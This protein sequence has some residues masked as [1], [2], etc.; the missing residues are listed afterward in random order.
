[1]V[2][3]RVILNEKKIQNKKNY[4]D[5]KMDPTID[6]HTYQIHQHKKMMLKLKTLYYPQGFGLKVK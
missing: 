3:V 1:M 4:I 5:F 6:L 2:R